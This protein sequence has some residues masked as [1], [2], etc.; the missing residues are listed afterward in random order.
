MSLRFDLID[1]IRYGRQELFRIQKISGVVL[2]VLVV[3]QPV[4]NGFHFDPG[5]G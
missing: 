1:M 3:D 4:M 5:V 2:V